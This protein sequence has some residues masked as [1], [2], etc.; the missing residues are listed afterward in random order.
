MVNLVPKILVVDDQ[1]INVKVLEKKLS[2][3]GM[4]V[5]EAYSGASA[6]KMAA[7]EKPD[8]ILLDIMMPEMDGVE[9]CRRLKASAETKEIPVIFITARTSREG[10]LEGLSSGAADYITKPLD[11]EETM[12]R[13]NTQ[14]A[15][16]RN[17]MANLELTRRLADSRRQAAISHVTEGIAHNLNNLLGVAVGYLD[18]MKQSFERP[19]RLKST[20]LQLDEAIQRLVKIVREL[21]TVAE[22]SKVRKQQGRLQPIMA[23]GI[24]R[25]RRD[26]GAVEVEVDMPEESI[27]MWTNADILEDVIAR[28]LINAWESYNRMETKTD[29]WLSVTAREV[30]DSEDKTFVEICVL[31]NG[32][33]I[34]DTIKDHVFDPFVTTD[35]SVGRGMGLTIVRHSIESLGG[36]VQL[37][38][39]SKGG[40]CA[41]LHHPVLDEVRPEPPSGFP[42]RVTA[43]P[44]PPSEFEGNYDASRP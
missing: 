2:Q 8:L 7:T 39:R 19:D 21:T 41:R 15:I 34:P 26:A 40:T 37:E 38:Q 22:F 4:T 29:R 36:T 42:A 12:A 6:L 28:L 3:H 43:S 32:P 13:V 18:I 30:L 24:E 44:F 9:V 20:C 27:E 11:L 35:S 14:L 31:D 17:H 10:K 1:P 23:A 5:L 33:G 16:R 25:F